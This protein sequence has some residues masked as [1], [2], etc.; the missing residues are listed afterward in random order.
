MEG[1][2]TSEERLM[3]IGHVGLIGIEVVSTTMSMSLFT[4][5]YFLNKTRKS[6]ICLEVNAQ[7]TSSRVYLCRSNG[8]H[9][10]EDLSSNQGELLDTGNCLS[11]TECRGRGKI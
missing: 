7:L 4:L 6:R 2:C 11:R 1:V 5:T 3:I 10:P 8:I 9:A